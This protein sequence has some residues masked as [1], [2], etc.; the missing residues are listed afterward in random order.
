MIVS[1][2]LSRL[3]RAPRFVW[4]PSLD[5]RDRVVFSALIPGTQYF[6]RTRRRPLAVRRPRRDEGAWISMPPARRRRPI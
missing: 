6:S 4:T 1:Y 3:N 2:I 5:L